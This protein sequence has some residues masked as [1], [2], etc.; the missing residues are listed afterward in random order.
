MG[1]TLQR[2]GKTSTKLQQEIKSDRLEEYD[3]GKRKVITDIENA[4]EKYSWNRF[5]MGEGEAFDRYLYNAIRSLVEKKAAK[6]GRK[7]RNKWIRYEDFY[8]VFWE[9]AWKACRSYSWADRFYLYEILDGRNGVLE[10]AAIDLAR[11]ETQTDKRRANSEALEFK[12]ERNQAAVNTETEA[13]NR[14]YVSQTFNEKEQ[15]VVSALWTDPGLSNA[16]IALMCGFG[17]KETV[18][19]IRRKLTEYKDLI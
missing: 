7:W 16:E 14:V 3:P 6:H 10:R 11:K 9:K 15:K 8:S 12:G 17:N 4:W 13:I 18:R 1:T 19:R 5:S 2:G